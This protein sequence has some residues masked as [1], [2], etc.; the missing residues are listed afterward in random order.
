MPGTK[1]SA[2]AKKYTEQQTNSR[3]KSDE[4]VSLKFPTNLG[5]HGDDGPGSY[6]GK[7]LFRNFVTEPPNPGQVGSDIRDIFGNLKDNTLEFFGEK[8]DNFTND[9]YNNFTN[10]LNPEGTASVDKSP[11]NANMNGTAKKDYP[12]DDLPNISN[13]AR[14]TGSRVVMYMPPALQIGDKLDIDNAVPFGI[15]GEV[16]DRSLGAGGGIAEAVIEGG[17]RGLGSLVD[18]LGGDGLTANATSLAL[19][20][21]ATALGSSKEGAIRTALGVT[22]NPNIRAVFRSVGMRSFSFTFKMT[23]RNA[24]E[25]REI[26]QIIK[27][28]R[29]NAYPESFKIGGIPAGY[30]FPNKFEISFLYSTK[31]NPEHTVATKA[32]LCFLTDIQSTYNPQQMAFYED[33]S[34]QETDLVLTFLEE[35]TLDRQDIR[36]GF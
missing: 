10:I 21:V 25:A 28:F 18:A 34:F 30:F 19:S 33:G 20:R 17:R 9:L 1:G 15:F 11:P 14:A 36:D 27:F 31:N 32:K 3:L 12:T 24:G 22:P 16:V 26:S 2:L 8:I 4:L 6:G 7:I 5:E 13:R 23:P 29:L 35:R